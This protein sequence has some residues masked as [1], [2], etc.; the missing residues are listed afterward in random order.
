MERSFDVMCN[1]LLCRM[2]MVTSAGKS[3]K[4]VEAFVLLPPDAR[5]AVDLLVETRSFVGI[6]TT[7][8]YI[9]ARL[10][11]DTPMTGNVE[12]QEVAMRCPGLVH[13]ERITSGSLRKYIATV[14]QVQLLCVMQYLHIH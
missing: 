1:V 6:P 5:Q 2:D 11:A 14:S 4:N 10:Q 9:F 13:P 7:N 12:L 3:R 8:P